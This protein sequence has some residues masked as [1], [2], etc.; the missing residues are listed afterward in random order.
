MIVKRSGQTAAI[1]L[2]ESLVWLWRACKG[3]APQVAASLGAIFS[4]IWAGYGDAIWAEGA[5]A[6]WV[7][8]CLGLLSLTFQVALQRPTYMEL[9]RR[10]E[11]AALESVSKSEAIERSLTILIRYL[12]E[13]CS[14]AANS[15]R[16]SVYYHH[17]RQFVMLARWSQN[18]S[19]K[20]P[21]RGTYPI[22]QGAIDDAWESSS[23]VVELPETRP[24]W[25]QRLEKHH[26]FPKGTAA[27]LTMH[28]QS[29]AALRIASN[30]DSVGVI[31][32]ES[33]VKKR[34][35]QDT[36]D[37]LEGS[38]LYATLR[39]LVATVAT[40]TPRVQEAAKEDPQPT[41]EAQL[42]REVRASAGR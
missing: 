9:S 31:V 30:G 42:W 13:H 3:W 4:L 11:E 37:T 16:V 32:F 14:M 6:F 8:V 1:R 21:G 29:I 20:T 41:P 38:M 7:A 28:S 35:T 34:A 23:A 36:L 25:N 22:G 17:D 24:R 15:D 18:P 5:W 19:F 2:A 39:E 12:A 40:L 26:G 33:T 10:E 27:A